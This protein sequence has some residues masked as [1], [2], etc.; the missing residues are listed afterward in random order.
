MKSWKYY[1]VKSG[2]HVHLETLALNE[3]QGFV[4]K[5]FE[6]SGEIPEIT[7]VD[8]SESDTLWARTHGVTEVLSGEVE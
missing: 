6:A 2:E 4:K 1:E 5:T 3:A 7:E 8:R